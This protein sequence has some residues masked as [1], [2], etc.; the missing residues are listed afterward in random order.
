VAPDVVRVIPL[1][2][3]CI[4]AELATGE[5]LRFGMTPYLD[6][7]AFAPLTQDGLF[8]KAHVANGAVAWNDEIDLS[9]DTLYLRGERV[10]VS[11]R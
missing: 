4:E 1:P 7:P 6:Y 3:Y 2:G 10:P 11:A 9:P 8:M 5:R